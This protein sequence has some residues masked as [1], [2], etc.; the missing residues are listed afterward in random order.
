MDK[1]ADTIRERV[2]LQGEIKTLTAQGRLSGMV[3]GF[4]PV[5]LAFFMLLVNPSYLMELITH[6]VGR[7]MLLMAVAGELVG[8]LFIR[9]IIRIRV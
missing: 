1:I 3:I 9:R 6:P 2:R 7:V 4:L 5:I 8:F